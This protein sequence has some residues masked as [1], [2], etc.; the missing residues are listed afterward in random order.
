M[1]PGLI[2]LPEPPAPG[3]FRCRRN[4]AQILSQ[5][6]TIAGAHTGL[7]LQIPS[8]GVR[9]PIGT[10]YSNRTEL[11]TGNESRGHIGFSFDTHSLL[12]EPQK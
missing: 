10:F 3:A 4:A 2:N 1:N 12:L 11:I 5:K 8:S 9:V 6:G 7:T